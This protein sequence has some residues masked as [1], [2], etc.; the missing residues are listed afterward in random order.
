MKQFLASG[1]VG[2]IEL[3]HQRK[4]REE[5]VKRWDGLG[6]TEGLTGHIKENIATL[7]ENQAK[8]ILK[9]STDTSNSGSF[10][11]VVFPIIRRVFSK[12]L[13]NDIASVQAMNM[14]IGKL[15]FLL[16][17]TSERLD[18]GSHYGMMGANL[19]NRNQVDPNVDVDA[20]V[21]RAY[22]PGVEGEEL[23]K[24][25]KKTLYDLF[26]DDFLYDHSKGKVTIKTG[27]GKAVAFIDGE[28]KEID[29]STIKFKEDA[30]GNV[31]SVILE[32]TGF[33]QINPS[34]L[35][36]ADGNEMDTESFL[37]SL[38]VVAGGD[39]DVGAG[40]P[41][42]SVSFEVGEEI[43][44]QVVTQRYGKGIVERGSVSDA[45]G[46]LYIELD[47]TKPFKGSEDGYAGVD[48]TKLADLLPSSGTD[49]SVEVA[50][51]VYDTLELET[52]IG[53]VSFKLEEV[54]VSVEARKLRATWSP[55]LAQDVAAF[56]N[57]DAEAELTAILSEQIA[58]EIDREAL[59]DLRHGAAHARRW[60]YTGWRKLGGFSTNY[61]QK[62]W[63][64]ELVTAINQVDAQIHKRTLRGG[65][66]FIVVSSE[67]SAIFNNLEFFHVSD[68]SA[69]QDTYNMGIERIGALASRYQVYRDPYAPAYSIIIGHRGKSM[70]DTGYVYAP[71]VPMQLT[72]LMYNPY[73]AAPIKMIMTRYAK[74]LVN[75][76]FY[77]HIRVD[78]VV[79]WDTSLF[80]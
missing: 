6:L 9:E 5:I 33:S 63:N 78:N 12:L 16:P 41:A 43:P 50:W 49:F 15:F 14:P 79:T 61:T 35:I 19:K 38:K 44:F 26:Y 34:K 70:L 21:E 74:K 80:R 65:A 76:N 46:K 11:T 27:G 1:A 69:E 20:T 77:G 64:Q 13:L 66:N 60:D 39:I 24:Y 17:V 2:S 7:Y 53:E 30:D 47:L 45:N 54:T 52:E 68:A 40:T 72:P 48:P 32:V 3:N 73:N 67:V 18:D 58:A 28:F 62:D 25:M 36:G 71:Y 56:Q 37:A 57:I 4:L 55:E 42:T 59:R 75:N 8:Y 29:G 10:E 31:R 51:A 22:V 23:P